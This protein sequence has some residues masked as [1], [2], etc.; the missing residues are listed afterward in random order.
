MQ[1]TSSRSASDMFLAWTGQP[2][3]CCGWFLPN[4]RST[5]QIILKQTQ[6]SRII[7]TKAAQNLQSGALN[8]AEI[9]T[10]MAAALD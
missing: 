7:A 6:M 8:R 10:F 1:R 4:F 5:P 9:G 2:T 3:G